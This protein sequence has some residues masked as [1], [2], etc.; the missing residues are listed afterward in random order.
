MSPLSIVAG[1]HRTHVTPYQQ[2]ATQHPVLIIKQLGL[3]SSGIL[4]HAQGPAPLPPTAA[5]AH[6]TRAPAF[7]RLCE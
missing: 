2:L 3:Y 6:L 4:L 1:T 7:T 5:P